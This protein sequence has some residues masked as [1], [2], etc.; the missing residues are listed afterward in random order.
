MKSADGKPVVFVAER[1]SVPPAS[2]HSYARPDDMSNGGKSWREALQ[3][4]NR[5]ANPILDERI[6]IC[7]SSR[8]KTYF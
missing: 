5:T 6:A 1:E 8:L 2:A 3:E 4:Y 7:R